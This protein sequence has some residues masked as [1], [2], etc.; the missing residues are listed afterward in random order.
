[1]KCACKGRVQARPCPPHAVAKRVPEV[2]SVREASLMGLCTRYP[3]R[4]ITR[5][6]LCRRKALSTSSVS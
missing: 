5:T 2:S 1:M 3:A 6:S 4:V